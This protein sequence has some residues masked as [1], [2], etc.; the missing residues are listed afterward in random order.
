MGGRGGGGVS[1]S[2]GDGRGG[3]GGSGEL[4]GSGEVGGAAASAGDGGSATSS[5]VNLSGAG[6]EPWFDL[7]VYGTGFDAEEGEIMRLAVASQSPNRVGL[8]DLPIVDGAFDL[9][10]PQVLNKGWYVG[11]TLYVDRN[12]NDTCETDEHVWD[13]T[14]RAVA[15][16]IRYDVTPDQLCDSTLGSCRP[17]TPTQ[18]ACWVGTG[19]TNLMEPLPCT[20]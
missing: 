2:G 14:T 16:D 8:A 18:E 13:W 15:S 11:V 7:T 1:G 10:M 20:P 17:R 19:D 12:H 4:A 5:C 6:D 3:D 9:S